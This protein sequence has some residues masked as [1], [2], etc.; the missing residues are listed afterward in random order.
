MT[1]PRS[2][3]PIF[4]VALLGRHQLAGFIATIV[5]FGSMIALVEL[6]RISPP[7]AAMA[8][9]TFGAIVNFTL[10]RV[11]AYRERHRGSLASQAS[12][13]ALV[14]AGGALLNGALLALALRFSGGYAGLRV[15]VA[16]LVS[17]FYTYPLHTRVV[18]RVGR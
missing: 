9:A 8:S 10:S 11:W 14:S 15:V 7:F 18:F 16:L 3:A 12:R 5:D 4:D 2:R 6:A 1:A 17:V 13:Y